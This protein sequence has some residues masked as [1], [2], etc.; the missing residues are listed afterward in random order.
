MASCWANRTQINSIF[1]ST[2]S[3]MESSTTSPINAWF[4]KQTIACSSMYIYHSKTT[5]EKCLIN[6]YFSFALNKGVNACKS[7]SLSFIFGLKNPQIDFH[8]IHVREMKLELLLWSNLSRFKRYSHRRKK[9]RRRKKNETHSSICH[10]EKFT[11]SLKKKRRRRRNLSHSHRWSHANRIL[12][13][14]IMSMSIPQKKITLTDWNNS[15]REEK[16]S[17]WRC[18]CYLFI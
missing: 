4:E 6:D 5:N 18:Y 11:C 8:A 1:R 13:R 15:Q 10:I 17:N 3:Q 12:M 7:L 14:R 16:K 2:A 9:T